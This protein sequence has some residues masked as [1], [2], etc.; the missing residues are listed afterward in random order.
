MDNQVLTALTQTIGQ[1]RP[2]NWGAEQQAGQAALF[3]A[4]RAKELTREVTSLYGVS[5]KSLFLLNLTVQFAAAMQAHKNA[6][7]AKFEILAA[8]W[9][10]ERLRFSSSTESLVDHPAYQ[11]IIGL[12]PEVI[13]LIL[14]EL[15]REPDY[16]FWA[17]ATLANTNPVP[18]E[19]RGDLD[20]MTRI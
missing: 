19:S 20:E 14:D 4:P 13:P 8:R 18:L 9:K 11:Q 10:T 12:G 5:T 2:A 6:L 17:L 15:R 7:K 1:A 16:W 3:V